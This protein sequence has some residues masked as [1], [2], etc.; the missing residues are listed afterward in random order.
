MP[1]AVSTELVPPDGT[2]MGAVVGLTETDV[3]V[4]VVRYRDGSFGAV[5]WDPDGSPTV[6][7][8]TGVT[9]SAAWAINEAGTAIGTAY[10]AVTESHAL[11]FKDDQ[12]LDLNSV[13]GAASSVA[14]DVNDSGR[15][16]GSAGSD[17]YS[18]KPLLYDSIGNQVIELEPLPGFTLG[19]TTAVNNAD[20]AAGLS[21]NIEGPPPVLQHVFF[22]D[23]STVTDQGQVDGVGAMNDAD[24]IVG[25]RRFPS[26]PEPQ[27]Y[28]LT[29]GGGFQPLGHSQLPGYTGS[30]AGDV[31][32]DGTVVGYSAPTGWNDPAIPHRAFV[33]SVDSG[34][35]DLA[36]ITLN[37]GA[38]WTFETAG[39]INDAGHIAGVGRLYGELR[40]FVL[41]PL[42]ALADLG[43]LSDRYALKLVGMFGGVEWGAGG[44]GYFPGGKP[45]P[46]D[47]HQWRQLP[48]ER[49]DWLIGLAIREVAQ[50]LGD[51]ASR[52][53]VEQA[54]TAVVDAAL[55]KLSQG[56]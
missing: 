53:T 6:L 31:N 20:H 45:V 37:P 38:G 41:K 24:T 28:R 35:E 48:P 50:L 39:A 23:G 26:A 40:G 30:L 16:A 12:V 22:Y 7:D 49:K 25:F 4:G 13:F 14:S 27:A 19:L 34:L 18:P 44:W 29:L 46:I 3:A 43:S 10:V 51:H 56:R 55:N 36:D 9:G 52:E 33:H 47:P 54:A 32:N 17:V 1:Y 2:G 42:D 21:Y 11:L 5:R 8:H 15:V